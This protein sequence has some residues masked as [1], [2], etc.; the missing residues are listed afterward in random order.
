MDQFLE[1]T[2]NDPL[3]VR[4]TSTLFKHRKFEM[5]PHGNH[6]TEFKFV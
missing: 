2:K 3:K 1:K 5:K 4:F 6:N